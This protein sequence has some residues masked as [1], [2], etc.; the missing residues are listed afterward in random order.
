[1]QKV[2]LKIGF[3]I[4]L[5]LLSLPGYSMGNDTI[6]GRWHG[7]RSIVYSSD[8]IPVVILPPVNIYDV[9]R[10]NYLHARKYRRL[11]YNVRRAYPYAVIARHRLK[12]LDDELQKLDTRKEQRQYLKE[13]EKQI[14]EE[15]EDEM[16]KMTVRQG[17]ILV[18]L[19][20][21]ETGQTSYEVIKEIRG[22]VTAFFWQGIARFF[23]ND[24]KIKYDP[25]DKDK[26]IEDIILAMEYGFL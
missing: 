17:I 19:I 4:F 22:S 21:R 25:E 5:A 6:P 2:T 10:F 13:A 14:M 12:A 9:N 3:I 1:M 18:K 23:G 16:R 15:F 7:Q 26:T 8:S 24:L 20:D 11:I